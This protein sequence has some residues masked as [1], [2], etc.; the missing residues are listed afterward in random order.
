VYFAKCRV[1]GDSAF[2]EAG[3]DDEGI[4]AASP[5]VE[6]K[7]ENGRRVR[8]ACLACNER[9]REQWV[10]WKS[11]CSALSPWEPCWLAGG[12]LVN[13]PAVH[14]RVEAEV[15]IIEGDE[16]LIV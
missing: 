9:C 4:E 7:S 8:I 1:S 12:I 3:N 15:G 13:K 2:N 14:S 6:Q 5:E 11:P 10:T 16:T